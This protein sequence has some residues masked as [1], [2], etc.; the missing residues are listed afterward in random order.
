[1]IQ[2]WSNFKAFLPLNILKMDF[3]KFLS[4][5]WSMIVTSLFDF[6]KTWGAILSLLIFIGTVNLFRK[7]EKGILILVLTPLVLHLLL[8]GF[9]LYPFDKR[10]ILYMVPC[11]IMLASCGFGCLVTVI[12]ED[13]HISRSGILALL[14][15]ISL[16]F[17]LY[18]TGF[19][20]HKNE[21]KNSIEFVHNHMKPTDKIY[22]NGFTKF[23]FQYYQETSSLQIDKKNIINGNWTTFWNGSQWAAD[24]AKY[25]NELSPLNGRVW[26]VFTDVGDENV[27]SKFLT[28]YL[29]G[30]DNKKLSEFYTYG[31]HVYLYEISKQI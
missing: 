18:E 11:I 15:P 25:S 8:S 22:L 6:G 12:F 31:S 23:P 17:H 1:M 14:I 26:F 10:L 27:K 19:P 24:T 5:N 3:F 30:K 21:I 4:I 28:R 2:D 29:M 9:K 16:S 7:R 13:L 20:I